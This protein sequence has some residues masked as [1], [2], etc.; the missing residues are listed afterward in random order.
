M[1]RKNY[2]YSM[3]ELEK[4]RCKT[5]WMGPI[6]THTSHR[7]LM[8]FFDGFHPVETKIVHKDTTFAFILFENEMW[9]DSAIQSKGSCVFKGMKT[10]VNRSFNA[11]EGPKLGGK[12]TYRED[13]FM[14]FYDDYM[15]YDDFES[16]RHD[17]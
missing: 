1:F 7:E 4:S 12:T 11:F 15:L 6:P 13:D 9:R 17:Y 16:R 10:V 2:G 5:A 14:D 3:G 8:Q